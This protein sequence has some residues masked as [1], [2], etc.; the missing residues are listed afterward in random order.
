[1]IDFNLSEAVTSYPED[2]DDY[3]WNSNH[4]NPKDTL[5][6]VT[7]VLAARPIAI[8]ED[9]QTW[10][11]IQELTHCYSKIPNS[12]KG[13]LA[14]LIV[15]SL[16]SL[17]ER[18]IK[19]AFAEQEVE[20]FPMFKQAL[21]LYGYLIF[22]M[23]T[24]LAKEEAESKTE[25]GKRHVR[26]A[27]ELIVD[28]LTAVASLLGLKLSY[29]FETTPER[30]M[31]VGN[32][33]LNPINALLEDPTRVK[34]QDIKMHAFKVTCLAVKYHGQ[35]S[36]VQNAIL[37][38]LTYFEHLSAPMAELLQILESHYEYPQLTDMVLKE[39]SAKSFNEN[40][41][42]GPKSISRF[43]T[44]L[45]E[46]SPYLV[47]TQMS[48]IAEL[49][50]SNS[51]TLRC[52]VVEVIGNVIATLAKS[53]EEY[54][55]HKEE[56]DGFIELLEE[57]LLDTNPY[58]RSRALQGLTKL[59]DMEVKFINRRLNWSGLA[60][61]H[62]EDRSGIVRRNAIKFLSHLILTHP[63]SSI[64]DERLQRSKWQAKFEILEEQLKKYQPDLFDEP[65]KAEEI[66]EE[67]T[68]KKRKREESEDEEAEEDVEV[69]VDEEEV[70]DEDGD[71][72]EDVDMQ[73]PPTD[74]ALDESKAVTTAPDVD[75]EM[76]QRL[77]L[78][79]QIYKDC[80][81]F[82]G[83]IE[84]ATVVG[85]ELLHSKSKSDA[86]DIMDF[87]VLCDAYGIETAGKGI[88]QMLHLVWMKGSNEEGNQVV[89][90]LINCYESLY[91]QAPPSD[92][93]LQ[94]AARIAKNLVELTYN[95][96]MADLASLEK[97]I[98][99]LYT[100][101]LITDDM[102]NFLWNMYRDD[103]VS[104]QMKRG[105]VIILGM[106]ALTNHEISLKGLDLLLGVG[107]APENTDLGLTSFTCIALRRAI[108]AK[109]DDQFRL[110]KSD[111]AIE[112]LKHVL[113]S[114]T[115]D[116]QWYATAEEALNT[117]YTIA[118][119]PDNI[120]SDILREK[121][122][123]LFGEDGQ[124]SVI[125][126]S[127]LFF[128]VGHTGLKTMIYLEKCEAEFKKKKIA[129]ENKKSEA[130][131]ELDMIGGTNED[132]FS[133]AVQAIKE[134]EMLYGEKSM[135]SQ[136][137]PLVIEVV[138]NP[139]AYHDPLLQ[140]QAI[141]CLCKMMCISPRF[142]ETHL[143]LL[144]DVMENSEDPIV[145]S[146]AVLGLGDMAV[147]FNSIIDTNNNY[148]Y[149]RLQDQDLTVQRTCLMTVT[150]LILAGQVKVK[151]QL[152][153]MAKLYIN[154][155]PAIVDMCKLFFAELATKENAIYNG[156]MDMFSG[157]VADEKLNEDE[158]KEIVKFVVPFIGRDRHR[159]QLVTKLYQ[160]LGK[161]ESQK[162]FDETS[163]VIKE[164][165]PRQDATVASRK[166]KENAKSKLYNEILETIEAG[167]KTIETRE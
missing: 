3:E 148:L 131:N 161:A 68:S 20:S 128:L 136:Y 138:K 87:F 39:V 12:I 51:F 133:D 94:K 160:R 104:K 153:Q 165:I 109:S 14:Y 111:E 57:R 114:F 73:V 158:F 90:N 77:T 147:C 5:G 81:Q 43:L 85:E 13:Q 122:K 34:S 56:A 99:E 1:M 107:L 112:K 163:F 6:E 76:L 42:K 137:V 96:S 151:G 123:T 8:V 116:G 92:T 62:F 54:D 55:Q 30:N 61:R 117:L 48:S 4:G 132:D 164:I 119:H 47:M 15:N 102:V 157:L 78:T 162:L 134:K 36:H 88:K 154:D 23:L 144:L 44:R 26:K 98:G 11:S 80:L 135:L 33:F 79:Y 59:T 41:T 149:K 53:Q 18:D 106:L 156:F 64:S 60:V 70:V 65:E 95:S 58:V 97:L 66:E 71:H 75:P 63:Y 7:D 25:V 146:N 89:D 22:V 2:A 19:P 125:A 118:V 124:N 139:K 143:S 38:H 113:L 103:S 17:I 100:R 140:R 130:D 72:D 67:E 74:K 49:L 167:Y 31:F 142:C 69:E 82:I 115:E 52:G 24:Q 16:N 155:D 105:S 84:R 9:E 93:E 129:A 46:L 166:D 21:E 37:Q 110:A 40:D 126:L 150:F 120:A 83:L 28:T 29:L 121:T 152:A 101:E 86:T 141:L 27:R 159:Q 32:L 145:R 45:S 50:D 10:D 108:P 35:V 127:Q 91:L